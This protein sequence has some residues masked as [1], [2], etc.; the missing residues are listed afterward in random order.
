MCV[1][2]ADGKWW[3]GD[4]FTR[5]NDATIDSLALLAPQS[6]AAVSSKEDTMRGE[7]RRSLCSARDVG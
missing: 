1:G 5:T 3:D 7:R 4:W 2:S 6:S